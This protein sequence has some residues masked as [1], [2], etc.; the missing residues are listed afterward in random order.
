MTSPKPSASSDSKEIISYAEVI[1][2]LEVMIRESREEG[3]NLV[4]FFDRLHLT[5][6][7]LI[8]M[9]LSLPFLQP[10]PLGPFGTVAGITLAVLGWQMWGGRE[11][12][13]LPQRLLQFRAKGRMLAWAL[14]FSRVILKFCRRFTRPRRQ[15]WVTGVRGRKYCGALIAIGGV[16][17][18]APFIAVPFNNMLPACVAFFAALGELEQDGN[19]LLV[20]LGWLV[21]TI[22]FFTTLT[23]LLVFFGVEAFEWMK[24]LWPAS[25]KPTP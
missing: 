10:I 15:E 19:M 4:E 2:Q 7:A 16:L 8:S 18:C 22:L 6:F 23:V 25:D 12:P 24:L 17:M 9:V 5:G 11:K 1:E 14:G 21:L 20:A 3:V 13:L